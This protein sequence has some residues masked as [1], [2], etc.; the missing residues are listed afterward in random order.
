MEAA[1]GVPVLVIGA[2][3]ML[4]FMGKLFA[5]INVGFK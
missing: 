4:I 2:L 3:L 5:S 1:H